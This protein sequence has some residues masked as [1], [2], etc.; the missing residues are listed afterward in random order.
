M[1]EEYVI[2]GALADSGETQS[3]E[4]L[5]AEHAEL[6]QA[7][8][9]LEML[10]KEKS[11]YFGS[12]LADARDMFERHAREEEDV[13]FPRLASSL[14]EEEAKKLTNRMSR[15]GYKVA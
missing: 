6:K 1:Q 7:L 9:D 11:P 13:A 12:R 4:A 15:E 2:Y 8:F 3:A 14:S 10:S 5:H